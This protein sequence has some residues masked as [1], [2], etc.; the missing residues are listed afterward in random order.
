MFSLKLSLCFVALALVQIASG[1]FENE[2]TRQKFVA[3]LTRSLSNALLTNHGRVNFDEF[4]NVLVRYEFDCKQHALNKVTQSDYKDKKGRSDTIE[5]FYANNRYNSFENQE[6]F[7]FKK[8]DAQ[9]EAIQK[10]SSDVAKQTVR[11]CANMEAISA[12]SQPNIQ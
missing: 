12:G 2:S 1:R 6:T 3:D 8:P 10:K 7:K 9:D 11:L 5:K 4:R